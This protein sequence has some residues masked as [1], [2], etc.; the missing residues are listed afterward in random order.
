MN[1]RHILINKEFQISIAALFAAVSALMMTIIIILLSVVL[2]SNNRK[3]DEIA[4]NQ[5]VLSGTQ[6]EIFKTLIALSSSK[7]LNRIHMTTSVIQQDN[8]NTKKLLGQ[9]NEK[10]IEITNRNY[11]IIVMLIVS[12]VI[13]SL[14]IFYLMIRRSHRISGPLFL[15]N[16]Y[17][18]ELRKGQNPEIRPIRTDDDFQDLFD[19]FRGLADMIKE[20]K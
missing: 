8:D 13:Q 10:I 15:L 11:Y 20:K 3:L 7:N 5:Q 6:G 9:N 12:A 18:D 17:I 1:K 16:R 14:I 19:N 4:V 2:I